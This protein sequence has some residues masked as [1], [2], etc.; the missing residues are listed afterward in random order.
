MNHLPQ[1]PLRGQ[2][3][4]ESHG[5]VVGRFAA[6]LVTVAL[7]VCACLGSGACAANQDKELPQ[8]DFGPG[9][10]PPRYQGDLEALTSALAEE[11]DTTAWNMVRRLRARLGHDQARGLQ[12]LRGV[13]AFVDG[14]ARVL[15]GRSRVSACSFRLDF[16]RNA[17]ARELELLLLIQNRWPRDLV[18]VSGAV[19][20]T[21]DRSFIEASGEMVSVT[22]RVALPTQPE[23]WAKSGEGT[24]VSLGLWP[25]TM[26]RESLAGRIAVSLKLIAP[27][28]LDGDERFAV[29]GIGVESN[30]YVELAGFL[31]TQAL[32][33]KDL[34]P[35]VLD[36]DI[37]IH[38]L[39]ERVVRLD[40]AAY[41]SAEAEILG[42]IERATDLEITARIAPVLRWITRGACP[43]SDPRE[44][45]LWAV[46]Q[47][48]K[49]SHPGTPSVLD[50]PG[51]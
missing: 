19:Q 20:L 32:Q 46:E 22:R 23:W 9:P 3:A 17:E 25:I 8:Q 11:L 41:G 43:G 5:P 15:E 14:C 26:A 33:P 49:T 18:F 47:K 35:A 21:V 27:K 1:H 6:A 39:I 4:D 16:R 12:D 28:V 36:A 44:W 24:E 34:V 7:T 10:V 29:G 31:P 48:N 38:G 45:R 30:P 50:L 51:S 13:R 2:P 40:P 42:L 37:G